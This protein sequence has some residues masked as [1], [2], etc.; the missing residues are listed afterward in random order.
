MVASGVVV[1][2]RNIAQYFQLEYLENV[3]H[4]QEHSDYIYIFSSGERHRISLIPGQEH[5]F[6]FS[7]LVKGEQKL[8]YLKHFQ[9]C[10]MVVN[11]SPLRKIIRKAKTGVQDLFNYSLHFTSG[12]IQNFN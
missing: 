1:S 9:V 10:D 5:C 4:F 8:K 12:N 3:R 7:Q 2:I 11:V 6:A